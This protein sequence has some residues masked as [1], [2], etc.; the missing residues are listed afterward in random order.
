MFSSS[1]FRQAKA[2]FIASHQHPVNIALHHLSNILA[3]A[4]IPLLFIDWRLSVLFVLLTQIFTLGGHAIF[5]KNEPAFIRFNSGVMILASL[6]WSLEN[7]FGLRQQGP[8]L[9]R[10]RAAQQQSR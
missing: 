9:S 8:K 3:I 4:A 7:W 2:H 1:Y 5:E 10:A 6:S